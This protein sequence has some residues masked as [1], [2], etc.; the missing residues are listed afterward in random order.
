MVNV[1]VEV[2]LARTG[3]GENSF[4]MR[5]GSTAVREAVA[6][7]L[8]PLLSPLSVEVTFPLT[9]L[10]GPAMPSVTV[11]VTV[12]EPLAARV[13]PDRLIVRLPV[14]DAV[15]PHELL[16]MLDVVSPADAVRPLAVAPA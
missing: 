5:G 4:E 9:L 14:T 2:P 15:P 8:A 13:P 12:Q 1:K 3:F 7:P 16:L 11:A 10:I 6:I